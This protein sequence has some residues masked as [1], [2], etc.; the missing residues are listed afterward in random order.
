MLRSASAFLI[1]LGVCYRVEISRDKLARCAAIG[2]S[3]GA[4]AP[5]SVSWVPLD[6]VTSSGGV[7][8]GCCPALGPHAVSCLP[9]RFILF[10][11]VS[12]PSLPWA[13]TVES[14]RHGISRKR[15]KHRVRRSLFCKK[16]LLERALAASHGGPLVPSSA[17]TKSLERSDG[18]VGGLFSVRKQVVSLSSARALSPQ[19][20]ALSRR[21][22][23]ACVVS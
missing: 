15:E 4:V 12:K 23:H 18:W 14:G 17:K 1:R 21:R 11:T 5:P 3:F 16:G 13:L 22:P 10:C 19:L 8:S 2:A 6:S 7:I 20:S 9:A